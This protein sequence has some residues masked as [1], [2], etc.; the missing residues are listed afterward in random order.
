MA[1]PYFSVG[2]AQSVC[3]VEPDSEGVILFYLDVFFLNNEF[4]VKVD[5]F[6]NILYFYMVTF[7][8]GYTI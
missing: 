7:L 5:L 3:V 6:Q 2:L 1:N 4:V 8:F